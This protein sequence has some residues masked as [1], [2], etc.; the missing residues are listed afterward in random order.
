[1]N[2]GTNPFLRIQQGERASEGRPRITGTEDRLRFRP[3]IG[4]RNN[5]AGGRLPRGGG[6][7]RRCD[8]CELAHGC[9]IERRGFVYFNAAVTLVLD[10]KVACQIVDSHQFSIAGRPRVVIPWPNERYRTE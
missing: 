4:W 8:E 3:R 6:S 10:I 5:Q 2:G 1:M 7:F 9:S